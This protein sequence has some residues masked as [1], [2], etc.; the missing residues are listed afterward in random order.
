MI[1]R[2]KLNQNF[3]YFDKET[4]IEIIDIFFEE[5]PDRMEKLRKN[6]EDLDFVQLKFNAHSLKGVIA[7]FQ[8][9]ECSELSRKLDE[10]AKNQEKNGLTGVFQDLVAASDKLMEELKGLRAEMAAK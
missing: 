8:D 10:M 6:I 4:I 7:N 1:D 9:P 3:Q 2:Q 5:Y